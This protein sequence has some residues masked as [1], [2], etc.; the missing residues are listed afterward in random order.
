MSAE[1]FAEETVAIVRLSFKLAITNENDGSESWKD[2]ALD[3]RDTEEKE[4]GS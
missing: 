4:M 2:I 3:C 1:R